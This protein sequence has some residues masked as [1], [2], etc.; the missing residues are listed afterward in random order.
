[1]SHFQRFCDQN[2]DIEKVWKLDF[3]D[4]VKMQEAK[5]I[6]SSSGTHLQAVEG[7]NKWILEVLGK[8]SGHGP[9]RDQKK[10][11]EPFEVVW[12]HVHVEI[13]ADYKKWQISSLCSLLHVTF[14]NLSWPELTWANLS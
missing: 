2:F 8:I 5:A 11:R 6:F 9:I 1:M 3:S 12:L 14:A 4:A 7:E 13:A 10:I